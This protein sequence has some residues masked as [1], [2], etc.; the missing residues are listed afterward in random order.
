[1]PF[2]LITGQ[3]LPH[4]TSSKPDGDSV[5]F[6][7]DTAELLKKLEG[8]PAV[9]TPKGPL[10]GSIQLRFEGIDAIEKQAIKPYSVDAKENMVRLIGGDEEE[11]PRGYI[12]SRMTDDK[13][14]RPI[15]FVFRGKKP[16]KE[17]GAMIKLT[18]AFLR[19]SVNY[20]Q[21]RDGY[22]YPLYYNTLFADL[23]GE[24]E[25]AVQ[26]AKKK[27]KGYWAEDKTLSGIKP[28]DKAS[29]SD[30][31]PIWPKLWRRLYE[32]YGKSSSISDFIPW[33]EKRNERVLILD[34]Q[35]ERGLQDIVSVTK[36]GAVKLTVDPSLVMVYG[37][38]G[39][40]K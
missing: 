40:R 15:S 11:T 27:G 17:N 13:G 33:L 30:V 34:V 14:G 6:L 2:L 24:F 8:K 22:A 23:R 36:S 4:N 12:L 38:A 21:L 20:G 9:P 7:P 16:P 31:D 3:F 26:G 28:T 10:Q 19:D 39:R 25:K 29:L 5:R 35:E 37:K 32:F 18:P 1:M